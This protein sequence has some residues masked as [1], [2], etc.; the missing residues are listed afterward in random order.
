[1]TFAYEQG[2]AEVGYAQMKLPIV[3]ILILGNFTW[4]GWAL[5]KKPVVRA[6]RASFQDIEIRGDAPGLR[7]GFIRYADLL[8]LP[9]VRIRVS[10]DINFADGTE[11]S[12]IYLE[13]LL[14][15]LGLDADQD[16][17]SAECADQYEAH[18][19]LDYRK[20]HKP[21]LVLKIEGKEPKD[22]PNGYGPYLISHDAFTPAFQVQS[23]TDEAQVPYGV[24][25]LE[26][27]KEANVLAAIAPRGVHADGPEMQGFKI[28]EQNCLR[29][30]NQGDVGGLKGERSWHELAVL[31]ATR[32]QYFDAYITR[33]RS[34]NPSAKMPAYPKYDAQTRHALAAYFQTFSDEKKP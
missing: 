1:M 15:A 34:E 21:I 27:H 10:N 24:V 12:G 9:Q 22:W 6:N 5:E 14:R 16:L 33:P 30:H 7:V 2:Y 28:A 29:C 17:V 26:I 4:L 20:E 3:L 13:T 11:V 8:A 23:H 31:A 19:P 25:R 32:P 18:Y